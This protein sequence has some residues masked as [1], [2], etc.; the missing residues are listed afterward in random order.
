MAFYAYQ[1]VEPEPFDEITK[2]RVRRG[3][4]DEQVVI[5]ELRE[6]Y[7]ADD[8]RAQEAVPWP[9]EGLPLGELHPDGYIVSEKT[10]V[11][12]KSHA[13]GE[14][15]DSDWVQLAGQ[16]RFHPDAED[17]GMLMVV[18]RELVVRSYPFVLT[19]AW[20]EEVEA[21]AVTLAESLADG[22]PPTRRCEKPSDA[23]GYF[24]P[25]AATCFAD[26]VPPDPTEWG[27]EHA[28]VVNEFYAAKTADE[29][30]QGLAKVTA[31]R[32]AEAKDALLAAGL[33][34]GETVCGPLRLKHTVVADSE[35][36]SFAKLR[37]SGVP[38][39]IPEEY[40][41][42]KGGHSR[43]SVEKVGVG[44]LETPDYGEDVPF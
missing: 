42:L 21:R 18:D 11:E 44:S 33:P 2:R 7:G 43:V 37:R 26:W 6:K 15:T 41:D 40:V 8:V 35:R 39:A 19:D 34:A 22:Q 38:Y 14:P 20:R 10:V 28:E 4:L 32:L 3:K 16:V 31:A 25:F 5:E 17:R 23:R 12:V 24:C 13:N 36:V 29:A 9:D 27:S 1:G 30:N